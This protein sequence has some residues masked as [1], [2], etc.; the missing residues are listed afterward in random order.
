MSQ[1]THD[2]TT[3]NSEEL[4]ISQE[5]GIGTSSLNQLCCLVFSHTSTGDY[6]FPPQSAQNKAAPGEFVFV[7]GSGPLFSMY[8]EMAGEEDKKMADSW[9]ADADGI[10]VFVSVI[11]PCRSVLKADS[12]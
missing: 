9:K 8:L 12:I 10:L 3:I 1:T 11:T 4:D 6:H 5:E 7:D 2:L